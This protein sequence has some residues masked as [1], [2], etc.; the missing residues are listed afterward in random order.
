MP[1]R[2][3]LDEAEFGLHLVSSDDGRFRALV[4]DIEQRSQPFASWAIDDVSNAAV[5]L[6]E[7][8][9]AIVVLA[10]VWSYTLANGTSRSSRF[11]NLGSSMQMEI[12]NGRS[13]VPQDIGTCILAGSKR[14]ITE[15]GMFGNNLDVLPADRARNGGSY[16]G[17]G[18]RGAGTTRTSEQ[19]V[20]IRLSLDLA[21]F[22][23]GL[24]VGPDKSG[25]LDALTQSLEVQRSTAQ[26]AATAI[27]NGASEGQ[28]FEMLLPWAR[29]MRSVAP[30]R[31]ER[32]LL[33]MFCRMAIDQ[34]INASRPEQ[35]VWFERLAQP[36]SLQ[37]HRSM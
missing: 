29:R 25:L 5:L 1:E 22:D 26:N 23:N 20:S 18:G 36:S 24:C 34:L 31:H 16:V 10:Y 4:R 27:R 12:L 14:L 21:I 28:L 32:V 11:A 9:R 19:I 8:G 7:S 37:L 30:D 17:A 6:N 2:E 33:P 35:L 15:R 3:Y 13:P